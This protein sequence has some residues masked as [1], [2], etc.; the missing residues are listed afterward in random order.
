MP[1][2]LLLLP[3]LFL[4]QTRELT[5]EKYTDSPRASET[6]LTELTGEEFIQYYFKRR[7]YASY[8]AR[9]IQ[10]KSDENYRQQME[11]VKEWN[12]IHPEMPF[13]EPSQ[14]IYNDL[15]VII[16]EPEFKDLVDL[17]NFIV[18]CEKVLDTQQVAGGDGAR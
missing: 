16:L 9:R 5:A 17:E 8:L 14:L 6:A 12:K 10:S 18:A 15:D 7:S 4:E 3:V 2:S 11:T 13:P 1:G